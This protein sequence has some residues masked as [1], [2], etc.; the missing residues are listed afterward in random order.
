MNNSYNFRYL[1]PDRT[2][3]LR[4]VTVRIH[5]TEN[6]VQRIGFKF[7]SAAGRYQ[8]S[9]YVKFPRNYRKTSPAHDGFPSAAGGQIQS[10]I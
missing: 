5:G 10:E 7:T 9:K 3:T 2:E 1:T 4:N 6:F 8:T